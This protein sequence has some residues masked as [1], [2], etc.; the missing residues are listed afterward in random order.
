MASYEDICWA[1]DMALKKHKINIAKKLHKKKLDLTAHKELA[2]AAASVNPGATTNNNMD[3]DVDGLEV[4]F[5]QNSP[6]PPPRPSGWPNQR[7]WLPHQYC[8]DLPPNP[9]LPIISVSKDLDAHKDLPVQSHAS[10]RSI[11]TSIPMS[12][13]FCTEKN[14]FGVYW[15]YT[16]GPPTITPD[17]TITLSSFSDSISIACDSADSQSNASWWSSFGSSTHKTLT[18][19]TLSNPSNN[20]FA[21]FLNPS[22]FLLMSWYYNSSSTK[23]YANVDKLIHNAIQHDDFKSSDFAG[24][25]STAHEAKLMDMNDK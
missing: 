4:P 6:S 12:A 25:F 18:N 20:Y 10:S 22:T 11:S 3:E 1:T 13:L 15:K 7:I 2:Q 14:S 8:D 16:L 24:T 9:N 19:M 23:S 21:P 17:K 5:T